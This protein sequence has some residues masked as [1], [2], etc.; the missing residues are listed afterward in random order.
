MIYT[1]TL[2]LAGRK[3]ELF[4]TKISHMHGVICP[5]YLDICQEHIDEQVTRNIGGKCPES[6]KKLNY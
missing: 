2:V 4:G 6:R 5:K 1:T 3:N